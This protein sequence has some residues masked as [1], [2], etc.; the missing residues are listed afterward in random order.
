VTE[1]IAVDLDQG[2]LEMARKLGATQTINAR[3]VK[4]VVARVKELTNG[5][6]A[7]YAVDCS[8]SSI[9]M[10]RSFFSFVVVATWFLI[11]SLALRNAY[12]V[13]VS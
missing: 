13:S 9:G 8:G 3:E 6:G 10:L 12:D 11:V 1:I 2:R 4:D 7:D 5:E